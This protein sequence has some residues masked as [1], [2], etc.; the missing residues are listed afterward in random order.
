[1]PVRL[2]SNS[3]Q[4]GG[5]FGRW[6]SPY[7]MPSGHLPPSQISA[8]MMVLSMSDSALAHRTNTHDVMRRERQDRPEVDVVRGQDREPAPAG[9]PWPGTPSASLRGPVAAN[10]SK[11]PRSLAGASQGPGAPPLGAA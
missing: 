10:A 11:I 3:A 2:D 5:T 4:P 1:M 7:V 8:F 9:P 6:N